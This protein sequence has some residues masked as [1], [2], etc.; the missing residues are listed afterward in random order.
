MDMPNFFQ[1]DTIRNSEMHA[2]RRQRLDKNEIKYWNCKVR[3]LRPGN[4]G[5]RTITGTSMGPRN[6]RTGCLQERARRVQGRAAP[7]TKACPFLCIARFLSFGRIVFHVQSTRES[8]WE[9]VRR[10]V[11]PG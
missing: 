7:D 6:K 5:R 2:I 8:V 11:V 10:L 3:D 4:E 1:C 9:R